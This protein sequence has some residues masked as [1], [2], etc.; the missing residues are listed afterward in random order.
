MQ[1][2]A[3]V[4]M[5]AAARAAQ[6]C[7]RVAFMAG[8]L[9]FRAWW[10]IRRGTERTSVP[11][12]GLIVALSHRECVSMGRCWSPTAGW[13]ATAASFGRRD[14][15]RRPC[16]CRARPRPSGSR[17]GSRGPR[18][19]WRR[20]C[21]RAAVAATS[22]VLSRVDL[23][24]HR[25]GIACSV[26]LI[27]LAAAL[28]VGW[29]GGPDLLRSAGLV[30]APLAIPALVEIVERRVLGT[31]RWAL[32]SAGTRRDLVRIGIPRPRPVP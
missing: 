7:W 6:M 1:P 11:N 20:S 10:H 27:C 8:T 9:D 21:W 31:S 3:R 4:V 29:E 19:G 24:W 17:A 30:V 15:R 23:T 12:T 25:D 32:M 5:V 18:F 14:F 13:V 28:V 26:L 16:P 2:A 22:L